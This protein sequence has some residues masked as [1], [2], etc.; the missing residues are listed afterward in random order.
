MG[1]YSYVNGEGFFVY[2]HDGAFTRPVGL[3]GEGIDIMSFRKFGQ[4][5]V[6]GEDKPPTTVD[7]ESMQEFVERTG[8]NHGANQTTHGADLDYCASGDCP[9][10]VRQ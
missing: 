1:Y 4:G 8:S 3:D 7:G 10:H 2:A 5:E 9:G 6:L